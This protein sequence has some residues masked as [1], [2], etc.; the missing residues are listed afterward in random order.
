[1]KINTLTKDM[2]KSIQNGQ[3]ATKLIEKYYNICNNIEE[4][5]ERCQGE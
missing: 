2:V 3:D 1:M 5:P 4:F